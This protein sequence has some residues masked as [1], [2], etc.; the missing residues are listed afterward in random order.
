MARKKTTKKQPKRRKSPDAKVQRVKVDF[1]G[2][3]RSLLGHGA[4]VARVA[5]Q[6][7]KTGATLVVSASGKVLKRTKNAPADT[8]PTQQ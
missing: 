8:P 2:A 7:L 3:T 1:A 6:G 4:S 5:G